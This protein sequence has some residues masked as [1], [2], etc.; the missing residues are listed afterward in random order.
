[1]SSITMFKISVSDLC[2]YNSHYKHYFF[3]DIFRSHDIALL[4]FF[5][6]C[7]F[8]VSIIYMNHQFLLVI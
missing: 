1:M 7:Q 6:H 2:K 8:H 5:G 3:I 4:F